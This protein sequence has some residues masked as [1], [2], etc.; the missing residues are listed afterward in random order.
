MSKKVFIAPGHGGTDSGAVANGLK[1]K[2]LNLTIS[3]ACRDELERHGVSVK[4]SRE[5]DV[6]ET[7]SQQT[8]ESNA[9]NPDVSVNIHNNAG[10]G[11][12]A[13]VF[14]SINSIN[15]GT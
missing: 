14:Y 8:N 10:G 9:F 13:E 3:L 1:E 4:M 5:T 2:D 12:G 11:D 15:G 7:L 6:A